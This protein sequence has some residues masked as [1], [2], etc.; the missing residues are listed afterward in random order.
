MIHYK[1][2]I[3]VL[4]CLLASCG[5]GKFH[6]NGE[7]TNAK[8]SVLYFEHNGLDGF[9]VLDSVKLDTD[10][11]FNFTGKTNTVLVDADKNTVAL[12]VVVFCGDKADNTKLDKVESEDY[13]FINNVDTSEVEQNA[14][15]KLIEVYT[16]AGKKET[17]KVD[18][19]EATLD[20]FY[21]YSKN[22]D[23]YYEL[24]D[25]T[26]AVSI[27]G[28]N[29]Q[30]VDWDKDEDIGV[31]EN[32]TKITADALDQNL[33]TVGK[34]ADISVKN[35]KF[36]DL[37]DTDEDGQYERSINSL[38]ALDKLVSADNAKVESFSISM[39][40]D[41]DGAIV[42]FLTSAVATVAP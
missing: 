3:P 34:L 1:Y 22:D 32:A 36:V 8:D 41:K 33:L 17:W 30:D 24:E 40:I 31:I 16:A 2:I 37:H 18:T 27:E 23:G 5:K 20:G 12:Y 10:G 6:V 25:A 9:K 39:S 4:L 29:G 13:I 26:E 28:D 35:A 15:Y 11:K 42:I 38:S 14:D 19:D 7:I 21:T